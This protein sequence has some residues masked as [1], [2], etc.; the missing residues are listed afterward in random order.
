MQVSLLELSTSTPSALGASIVKLLGLKINECRRVTFSENW[1][2]T[3]HAGEFEIVMFEMIMSL[4]P[5]MCLQTTSTQLTKRS[6][7]DQ[8]NPSCLTEG[9]VARLTCPGSGRL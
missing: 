3:V 6:Q 7:H 9:P 8:K 4:D 2:W 1:K 5:M